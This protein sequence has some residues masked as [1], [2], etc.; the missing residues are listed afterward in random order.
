[1]TSIASPTPR[2]LKNKKHWGDILAPYFFILPFLIFF[3]VFFVGPA[4]YS[5]IL[6]FFRYKGYGDATFIGFD[7]YEALLTYDVFWL[8]LR[9]V[10]FYW[11]AHATPML[12]IAFLL[13][14][15]IKSKL[16]RL[17]N[18][19]KP[20]LFL[21]QIVAGVASALLFQNFF[22]TQYGALNN[23]LGLQIPWLE[24]MDLARWAVVIML[25]WRGI[26][27]W[28]VIFL[29]GLTSVNEEVN[30]AATV[31]GASAL[32]RLVY[33]TIPLMRNTILFAMVIDAI[34]TIRIYGEP[35]IL[36][37][38]AGTLAPVDAAPVLNLVVDSIRSA[39][40]G[41]AAAAGWLIFI[42]TAIISRLQFLIV[43]E[44]K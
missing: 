14:V 5:L 1:M 18:I 44:R 2:I 31:D 35:N 43:G 28:F 19:F 16:I 32:Q 15:F 42:I 10:L 12:V 23:M 39:R 9:N 22:G 13:A 11:I 36:V 29:A 33:I 25:V 40:F 17:K 4:I 26:G 27:Y 20:I 34:V 6:S 38:K 3:V 8:G 24:N 30:E 7:N 41:M 21:P 37:G